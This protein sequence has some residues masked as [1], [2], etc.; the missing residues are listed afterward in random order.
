MEILRLF[1]NPTASK[2]PG[3]HKSPDSLIFLLKAHLMATF[4]NTK[5]KDTPYWAS[6]MVHSTKYFIC[7]D[8]SQGYFVK[9]CGHCLCNIKSWECIQTAGTSLTTRKRLGI[10]TFS[11]PFL[12]L[13]TFL[14]LLTSRGVTSS[15]CL[16]PAVWRSTSFGYYFKWLLSRLKC[17]RTQIPFPTDYSPQDAMSVW[18]T[19]P[20]MHTAAAVEVCLVVLSAVSQ[21]EEACA[22]GIA[23]RVQMLL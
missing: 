1:Q 11:K 12:N 14:G 22:H 21:H 15:T 4:K 5:A 7:T 8:R 23:F 3:Q 18:L 9:E 13:F 20:G 2:E 16:P 10:C 17:S 6:L 19:A